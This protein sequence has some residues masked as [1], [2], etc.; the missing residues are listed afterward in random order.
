[1]E[2]EPLVGWV[3]LQPPEAVQICAPLAFQLNVTGSPEFTLFALNCKEI[4]GF[5]TAGVAALATPLPP[6]VRE[7]PSQAAND[8]ITVSAKSQREAPAMIRR[9]LRSQ[10]E[11]ERVRTMEELRMNPWLR[12]AELIRISLSF[13]SEIAAASFVEAAACHNDVAMVITSDERIVMPIAS[14]ANLSP[15]GHMNSFCDR[16]DA[17]GRF[18]S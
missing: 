12:P 10:L 9:R 1:V 17:D 15:I 2:T 11:F 8:E 5:A 13:Y 4:D 18:G 6:G 7:S 14:T 3:P 16:C